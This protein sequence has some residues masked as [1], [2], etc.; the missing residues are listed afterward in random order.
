MIK[1]A[2]LL[3]LSS[4]WMTV[5]SGP[6]AFA[7][8]PTAIDPVAEIR[9]LAQIQNGLTQGQQSGLR[10]QHVVIRSIGHKFLSLEPEVW[11]KP[12]NADAAIRFL[13]SG[14]DPTFGKI[15]A[16]QDAVPRSRQRVFAA[17]L[18]FADGGRSRAGQLLSKINPRSMP[19][20]IA[21]HVALVA[22]I[23]LSPKKPAEARKYLEDARLLGSG[24]LIE[25]AAI[26]RQ[27]SV[28][29]ALKDYASFKRLADTYVL[30][31]RDSVYLGVFRE[32][33]S[34]NVLAVL[35]KGNKSQIKWLIDHLN[36]YKKDVR[37]IYSTLIA[38]E[39]VL[40]GRPDVSAA[41]VKL[42]LGMKGVKIPAETSSQLALYKSATSIFGPDQDDGAKL[43]SLVDVA[44]LD[45][46]D[47][48][49]HEAAT[50]LLGRV[51]DWPQRQVPN[52]D[53]SGN[54][55][56]A[57]PRK[58]KTNSVEAI[59]KKGEA[60]LAAATSLLAR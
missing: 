28:A 14:G 35:K 2:R 16:V 52:K 32:R 12:Q 58:K 21:G 36:K 20:M 43:L 8:D 56:T 7:A 38:R 15:R 10:V 27:I 18:A 9:T 42:G 5:A 13:L 49:I 57:Q 23:L 39:A 48:A 4:C 19:H 55:T 47:V 26:R 46:T 37:L 50:F 31:F 51:R 60:R 53:P 40:R 29:V 54:T 44:Q 25:E 30:H 45:K 3:A 22:G 24:T 6:I 34:K 59:L 33:F 17:A 1:F 11:S 41:L